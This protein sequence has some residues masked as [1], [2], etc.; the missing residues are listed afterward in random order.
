LGILDEHYIINVFARGLGGRH[1]I[2]TL[3]V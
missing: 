1:Y 2:N 3:L